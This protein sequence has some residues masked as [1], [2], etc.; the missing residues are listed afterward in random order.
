MKLGPHAARMERSD[1][2]GVFDQTRKAPG[3]AALHPG[4]GFR[5]SDPPRLQKTSF[6]EL[7]TSESRETIRL[8]GSLVLSLSKDALIVQPASPSMS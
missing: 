1:I 6:D 7:R 4:Y 8:M 3:I 2:R 5:T